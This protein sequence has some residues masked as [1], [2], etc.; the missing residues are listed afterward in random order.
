V[1]NVTVAIPDEVYRSARVHAAV[2][3][4]SLSALVTG[5]LRSLSDDSGEFERLAELQRRTLDEVHAFQASDRLSREEV[6][7]RALL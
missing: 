5:F 1:R 4:T 2:A 6:H 3:D 7:D